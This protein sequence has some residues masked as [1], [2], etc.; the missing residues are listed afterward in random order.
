M[1]LVGSQ[2]GYLFSQVQQSVQ[3]FWK[4]ETITNENIGNLLRVIIVIIEV[5]AVDLGE[6]DPR[7]VTFHEDNNSSFVP[8][9][10]S[11]QVAHILIPY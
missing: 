9:L 4:S 2:N 8:Q 5:S 6:W 11:S 3:N 10:Y 7:L 1:N